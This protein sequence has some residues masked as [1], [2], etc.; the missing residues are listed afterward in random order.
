MKLVLERFYECSEETMSTNKKIRWP[1][2]AAYLGTIILIMSC[3]I[4]SGAQQ[5]DDGLV[6]LND[7]NVEVLD[8]NG[9]WVSVAGTSFELIGDLEN[10]DP[11]IVTGQALETRD[12]TLIE[13]GLEVGDRVRVRGIIL[14]DETWVAYSIEGTD[15]QTDPIIVLIGVVDSIDPWSVNGISINVTNESDIQGNITVGMIVRVEILLLEDG[16]WEVI[17]IAPLGESTE[18][19]GCVTVVVTVVSV[20]GNEIQ[21][22]GWP[23]TVT[24]EINDQTDNANQDNQN[25]NGDEE[26]G[27]DQSDDN[28]NET[29]DGGTVIAAGDVVQA[30]I[31]ISDDGTLVIVQIT[32]L[33][34]DDV[35]NG[36]STGGEKVLICHKPDKKGGNT[37][38][39]SSSAVPAH[40][41]H[42]DKLG[43]CP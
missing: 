8:Q 6:H 34:M 5:S 43:A 14:E 37:L 3:S 24:L 23:T 16:T 20:E 42:G 27:E 29:N 30:A 17:S 28:V 25:N 39:I 40:L 18:T 4:F 11:W 33:H 36:E 10:T 12:S 21:F 41:A 32:I 9:D 13:D 22:L 35:D 1:L 26:D 38:S 31:C 19:S 7:N 15:E 2:L